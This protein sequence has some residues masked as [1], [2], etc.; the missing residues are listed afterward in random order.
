MTVLSSKVCISCTGII[1][2]PLCLWILPLGLQLNKHKGHLPND[3]LVHLWLEYMKFRNKSEL[4]FL[5]CI[6]CVLFFE[7][8]RIYEVRTNIL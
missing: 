6:S 7:V 4:V 8:S 5:H 3:K 2:M 1:L